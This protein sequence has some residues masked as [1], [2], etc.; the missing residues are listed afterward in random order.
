MFGSDILDAAIGLILVYCLV[1]PGEDRPTKVGGL[2]VA[3][4]GVSPGAPFGF[5]LLG[6]FVNLRAA[7][8]KPGTEKENKP[9]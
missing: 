8:R 7:G 9:R 1:G 6:R 2:L 5:D 4:C 3:S